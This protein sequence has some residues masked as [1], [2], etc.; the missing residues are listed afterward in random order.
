MVLRRMT[1]ADVDNLFRLNSDPQVMR[2]LTGGA[3]TPR[4][5][6]RDEIIPFQLDSYE[7]YGGL[8][9]WA[10]DDRARGGFLG[11]FHL[12]PRNPDG[13]ID[14]GYRLRQQSWGQGLATE[15][16]RA[17]IDKGFGELGLDRIVAETM[18]A[19]QGSRRVMEKCG[20]TLARTYPWD[21]TVPIDGS[22][23]GCVEYVLT[24]AD[25]LAARSSA[26]RRPASDDAR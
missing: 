26:P 21:G 24:R 10:A 20:M 1:E 25:W 22:E 19:N 12:R 2:Y 16:S 13:V 7:R 4:E 5:Q 11:W 18:A 3:A 6:I 14:L 9:L 15:G 23:L 8:G 17:L